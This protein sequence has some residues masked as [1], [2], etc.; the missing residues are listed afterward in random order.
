MMRVQI[1]T[2][3]YDGIREL[4]IGSET[5]RRGTVHYFVLDAKDF[6]IKRVADRHVTVATMIASPVIEA[7]LKAHAGLAHEQQRMKL[8]RAHTVSYSQDT[9][10]HDGSSRLVY[11]DFFV[12]ADDQ[13]QVAFEKAKCYLAEMKRLAGQ[14]REALS[15]VVK[16]AA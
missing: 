9:I 8:Y 16:N 3:K 5:L 11:A 15:P 10:L 4:V 2:Y 13:Y 14:V 12:E 7:L 1:I 6:R